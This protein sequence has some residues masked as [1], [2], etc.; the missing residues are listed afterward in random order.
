VTAPA[1]AG[2]GAGAVRGAGAATGFAAGF[3][4]A[5]VFGLGARTADFF[6]GA[7]LRDAACFFRGFFAG[8]AGL[9]ATFAF[10]AGAFALFFRAAT[11]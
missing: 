7:F 4:A 6:A 10:F 3:A 9:E 11:G 2:A 1:A 5:T 8:A